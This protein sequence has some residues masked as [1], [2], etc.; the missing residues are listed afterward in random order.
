MTSL[1][2]PRWPMRN[3][4]SFS[5]DRPLPSDRLKRLQD[6]CAQAVGAVALGHDHGGQRAGIL[7]RIRALDLEAPGAGRL[8][9]RRAVARMAREHVVEAFL[10][11]HRDRLAQAADQVAR[12]RVGEEALGIGRE[13]RLPVPERARQAST[14]ARLQRLGAHRIEAEARRQHQAL[15]RAADGDVDAPL[16]V[17]V[18]DRGE[19]GDGVDHEEGRVARPI[20]RPADLL[21]PAH[22]AGGGLVVDDADRLDRCGRDPRLS[23]PRSPPGRR[24]DASRRG[25]TRA[26]RRGAPP[27]RAKGWRSGRSRP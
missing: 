2:S 4:R 20:D 5:L 13:H 10:V 24:H 25:G 19:R 6:V 7:A 27:S 14:L 21:D 9:G 18:V 1:K 8:A 11:Q 16:V 17:A 15:L 26:A 23:G 22:D 3:T 12:R